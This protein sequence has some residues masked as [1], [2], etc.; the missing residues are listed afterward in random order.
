M[1]KDNAKAS[2]NQRG[3]NKESSRFFDIH[4]HFLAYKDGTEVT[5]A[6]NLDSRMKRNNTP[7]ASKK[8]NCLVTYLPNRPDKKGMEKRPYWNIKWL[9][10]GDHI[11]IFIF[12]FNQ[13]K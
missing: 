3:I 12:L 11:V 8:Q 6:F 2:C 7:F 5:H 9:I 13:Q 4:H 1:S 10:E